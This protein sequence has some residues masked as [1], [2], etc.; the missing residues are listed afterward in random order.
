[1]TRPTRYTLTDRLDTAALAVACDE[2]EH[3]VEGVNML[4]TAL[5]IKDDL[6]GPSMPQVYV[7]HDFDLVATAQIPG[8][9]FAVTVATEQH[10]WCELTGRDDSRR[11]PA[12]MANAIRTIVAKL[13]D[14][15]DEFD[16]FADARR[17][18]VAFAKIAAGFYDPNSIDEMVF[19]P[20]AAHVA[21]SGD[22]LLGL[23]TAVEVGRDDTDEDEGSVWVGSR[24]DPQDVEDYL[25][26]LDE[27]QE[28]EEIG[29]RLRSAAALLSIT[30]TL[31]E[32]FAVNVDI[33]PRV[34]M[35]TIGHLLDVATALDCVALGD[36]T[37]ETVTVLYDRAWN[38]RSFR[39]ASRLRVAGAPVS[40]VTD[41]LPTSILAASSAPSASL[42]LL[43]GTEVAIAAVDAA[44]AD[45]GDHL[46]QR[47]TLDQ[48]DEREVPAAG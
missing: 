19:T 41:R 5:W 3:P 2:D 7:T 32:D 37:A 11:T 28:N 42:Q 6:I 12:D 44:L 4:I 22:T 40:V 45:L 8:E 47:L 14:A 34:V 27:D 46:T 35:A 29:R 1:M 13:N 23:L 20:A 9:P 36:T 39:I 43:H 26:S 15:L 10:G 48:I 31:L 18:D 17:Q 24:P 25:E 30:S 38:A 16:N 21:L 33:S